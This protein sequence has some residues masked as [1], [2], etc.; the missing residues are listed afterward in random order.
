MNKLLIQSSNSVITQEI[1]CTCGHCNN[2][3]VLDVYA[4]YRHE[5]KSVTGQTTYAIDYYTG[6]CPHCGKPIII[7]V[8]NDVMYP[9]VAPFEEIKHLPADIEKLFNECKLA[10]SIGAYTCCVITARTLMANIAVEQG[11]TEGNKF[12]EYVDYLKTNCLPA[13]T[14]NDWVDKI[15]SL[16]NESTH[17]LAIAK[18]DDASLAIKFIIAILKNVYEFPNSI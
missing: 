1:T 10:Y 15:R 16:A 11:A 8:N 14:N 4:R 18:Q 3:I 2:K 17:H 6:Q 9:P 12:V 13:R 7:D 5:I